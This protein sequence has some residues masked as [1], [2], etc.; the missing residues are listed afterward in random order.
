MQRNCGMLNMDGDTKH[1]SKT[2][3]KCAIV[4]LRFCVT[5]TLLEPNFSYFVPTEKNLV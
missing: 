1:C 5:N 2:S 3:S 4:F